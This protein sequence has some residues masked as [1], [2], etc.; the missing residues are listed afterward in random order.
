M[1]TQPC[2]ASRTNDASP[3]PLTRS[4]LRTPR[5]D[6][7]VSTQSNCRSN[8]F[9]LPRTIWYEVLPRN[10]TPTF[11]KVSPSICTLAGTSTSVR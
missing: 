11:A 5:H 10:A 6:C 4:R 1:A 3:L 7:S 9:F 8:D 2:R